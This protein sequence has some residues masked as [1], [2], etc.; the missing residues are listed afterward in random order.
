MTS[1]LDIESCITSS[2]TAADIRSCVFSPG[3]IQKDAVL[4]TLPQ[5]SGEE[6]DTKA[7]GLRAEIQA[8]ITA[9]QSPGGEG[10]FVIDVPGGKQIV[11]NNGQAVGP[12]HA[13]DEPLAFADIF[14]L[15]EYFGMDSQ[16]VRRLFNSGATFDDLQQER[17]RMD[18]RAA[19]GSATPA[20]LKKN[21][22]FTIA[23]N[24]AVY[25]HDPQTGDTTFVGEYPNLAALPP[26]MQFIT[27]AK[28]GNLLGL[29]PKTGAITD[30]GDKGWAQ[31]NPE[32]DFK[33]GIRRFDESL[34]ENSRQFNTS[35]ERLR[36]QFQQTF[37]ESARQFN[38]GFSQQE[39]LQLG[40]LG[41][42]LGNLNLA[43]Q[44][45]VAELLRNPADA[46]ARLNLQRGGTSPVPVV[47]TA[48]L[49]NQLRG[50]FNRTRDFVGEQE[51]AVQLTPPPQLTPQAITPELGPETPPPN[52]GSIPGTT[53]SFT[54]A[55][56]TVHTWTVDD[57]GSLV[58]D[59]TV[60]STGQDPPPDDVVPPP[61]DDDSDPDLMTSES[62]IAQG[63]RDYYKDRGWTYHGNGTATQIGGDGV[64]RPVVPS[65]VE[66]S[67]S[68]TPSGDNGSG[69]SQVTLSSPDTPVLGPESLHVTT[70]GMP[71]TEAQFRADQW[72]TPAINPYRLD[73]PPSEDF[74]Y[75]INPDDPRVLEQARNRFATT[76]APETGTTSAP[77]SGL[78]NV[79]QRAVGEQQQ[80]EYLGGPS[81]V[82]APA[83]PPVYTWG[84]NDP[85]SLTQPL[86]WNDPNYFTQN[87]TG[88]ARGG[89]VR[90]TE[91]LVGEL[92][93]QS[94][95]T[96]F[97]PTGA[98]LTIIPT[99]GRKPSKHTRGF[100]KGT[101]VVPEEALVGE[102]GGGG[103][104]QPFSKD[105]PLG[106]EAYI[107]HPVN[108][109]SSGS[110]SL[111]D[112]SNPIVTTSSPPASVP[113][114]ALR[115]SSPQGSFGRLS[116]GVDTTPVTQ[117]GLLRQSALATTPGPTAVLRGQRAPL[118]DVTRG[119]DA[120][121]FTPQQFAELT[122]D[123]VENLR[124][125][126]AIR[127]LS[128]ED[129]I[130]AMNKRFQGRG[131]VR[132]RLQPL[133]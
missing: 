111:N 10:S 91:I 132:G 113:T 54:T 78:P 15:A 100:Q 77:E 66:E 104:N 22:S 50:E 1:I 3:I 48:D 70:P 4:S 27:D 45:Q 121:L 59:S 17:D 119:S 56:G 86:P 69:S 117:A 24:G 107:G 40:N 63:M 51:A 96:V 94:T 118:L 44:K 53:G 74:D 8:A 28:T 21:L 125:A 80:V 110:T 120:S 73:P 72:V 130:F 97:N 62:M 6:L 79:Q 67:T 60:E 82:P 65:R 112:G 38:V 105:G 2:D 26:D 129:F 58:W 30:L 81:G 29:D 89:V 127:N 90:D 106:S 43:Q 128:L 83:L 20:V 47:T 14:A 42:N 23:Q 52:E 95:E 11:D 98:P 7:P 33:E 88:F 13:T 109:N 35:E 31:I 68:L 102:G 124:S 34:A 131:N 37:A 16:T 93:P 103:V 122:P 57:N 84:E 123:E 32:R 55:D 71:R 19:A 133:G 46:L 126:L 99:P 115:P 25:S 64:R 49:I 75:A 116:Q 61:G 87:P 18:K 9:L 101:P 92:A 85:D 12:V 76:L 39:R 41:V 108:P 36:S 5:A 114:G